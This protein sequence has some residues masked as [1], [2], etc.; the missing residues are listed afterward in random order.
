MTELG[1]RGRVHN[2]ESLEKITSVVGY[3]VV[4]PMISAEYPLEQARDALAAVESGHT[5]GK[6]VI[7]P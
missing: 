7:V 5:V 2:A 3:E 4:T 1:G 6:V